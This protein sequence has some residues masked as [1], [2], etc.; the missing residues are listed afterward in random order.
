MT[1]AE[2]VASVFGYRVFPT[3]FLA[4]L[5]YIALFIA[6][7]VTDVLP[8]VPNH[9]K[10]GGLDLKEAYED[11]R[12]VSANSC[13]AGMSSPFDRSLQNHIHTTHT[14]TIMLEPTFSID[15]GFWRKNTI[16]YK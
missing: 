15:C 5:T 8:S 13:A 3:S 9:Q 4:I 1:L 14:R 16:A 2:K 11:L 6:L 10:Q 12:H 7:I